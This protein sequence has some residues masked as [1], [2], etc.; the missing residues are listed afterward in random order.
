MVE[1]IRTIPEDILDEIISLGSIDKTTLEKRTEYLKRIY[2]ANN[3]GEDYAGLDAPNFFNAFQRYNTY[4]KRCFAFLDGNKDIDMIEEGAKN[5]PSDEYIRK[6]RKAYRIVGPGNSKI[7]KMRLISFLYS[8]PALKPSQDGFRSFGSAFISIDA[9]Y[10][11]ISSDDSEE[12]KNEKLYDLFG[13]LYPYDTVYKMFSVMRR[14]YK[15]DDEEELK[16]TLS[17]M[18][19]KLD[20]V[21][22]YMTICRQKK[23]FEKM[24]EEGRPRK[25][26]GDNWSRSY[27]QEQEKEAVK[28][29]ELFIM[30]GY[31]DNLYGFCQKYNISF[32]D[33]RLMVLKVKRVNEKLYEQY[34]ELMKEAKSERFIKLVESVTSI[35]RDIEDYQDKGQDMGIFEFYSRIP[36][37][38]QGVRFMG[39]L[40]N[41]L[42]KLKYP[43][44]NKI[45]KE[46]I[47]RN[48]I[49]SG[50]IPVN[51]E[52]EIK[53]LENSTITISGNQ[54]TK[55]IIEKV[56]RYM[57]A[58][59]LPRIT[60]IYNKVLLDYMNGQLDI[61]SVV[62]ELDDK[63]MK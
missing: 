22:D 10:S 57:D 62:N 5:L 47:R 29:V 52:T 46:Y 18:L 32:N 49:K 60:V 43:E 50:V 31:Q 39:S 42:A 9:A 15:Y 16:H 44:V 38:S 63:E 2:R 37:K 20:V 41:F 21:R 28:Y 8:V 34:D 3:I 45:I 53:M 13:G 23:V 61:D 17:R 59:G 51:I 25:N 11:I 58:Y 19:D 4:L 55:E 24:F 40:N 35:A 7:D 6:F 48:N 26:E 56:F 30:G 1:I 12:V 14:M 36:F 54:V 27:R 33:F